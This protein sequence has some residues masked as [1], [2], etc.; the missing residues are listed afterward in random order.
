MKK[1]YTL[2][3]LLTS[4]FGFSQPQQSIYGESIVNQEPTWD[5][6]MTKAA[7]DSCGTYYNNYIGLAKTQ[8]IREESMRTGNASESGQYNGRAQRFYAP[9]PIEVSGVEYYAYI[10]NNPGQDSIMVITTLNDYT[11][12]TDSIGL[13]LARDTSYVIHHTFT[14]NLPNMSTK[15]NFDIPVTVTDDYIISIYTPTDDSLKILA[16]DPNNFEGNGENLAHALYD[17]S[18]YPSFT[19]W[20]SM[21]GDFGFDYDFLLAPMVK[22]DLHNSF[23]VINDTICPGVAGAACVNYTQVPVFTSN[24]YNVNHVNSTNSI[25]WYWDDGTF[26]SGLTSACHMY[27]NA[28]SYVVNLQDSIQKWDY[29]SNYCLAN[30][31]ETIVAL[32]TVIADFTIIQTNIIVDFTNT[33]SFADSVSWDFGDGTTDGN[34]NTTEHTYATIGTFDVWLHVYNDCTQDSIMYQVTTDDVGL[35]EIEDLITIFPN[36]SN[37]DITINNIPTNAIIEIHNIL[38]EKIVSRQSEGNTNTLNVSNFS[39]GTY[40][41]KINTDSKSYTKKLIIKH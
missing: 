12:A 19:G 27:S 40:F 7:G 2:I 31:T 18:A 10:K 8:L 39:N 24:Q 33:S 6:P 16:N 34:V 32:D 21:L 23:N 11:V 41:V 15:S 1:L 22:H 26:N 20:Y 4:F 38:G 37:T 3:L 29:V 25:V 14:I 13:E 36:P 5:I 17:N 35:N 28:G 9:Q 30:I